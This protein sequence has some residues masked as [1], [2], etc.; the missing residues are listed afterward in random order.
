ML[1]YRQALMMLTS[2]VFENSLDEYTND[3]PFTSI[4]EAFRFAFSLDMSMVERQQKLE[5]MSL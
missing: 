1:E 4:V 5:S 3:K 2:L